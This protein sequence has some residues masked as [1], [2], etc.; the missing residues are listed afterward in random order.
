MGIQVKEADKQTNERNCYPGRWESMSNKQI[1]KLNKQTNLFPRKV[2]IQV[3]SPQEESR[4]L[5]RNVL[6]TML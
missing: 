1:D 6:K 4:R 2:G 3:M 5:G